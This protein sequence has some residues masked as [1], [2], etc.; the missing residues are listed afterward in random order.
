MDSSQKIGDD[1]QDVEDPETHDE[2]HGEQEVLLN[3][4]DQVD[5]FHGGD[6]QLAAEEPTEGDHE[7]AQED[8]YEEYEGDENAEEAE[9]EGDE[10]ADPQVNE[11]LESQLNNENPEDVAADAEVAVVQASELEGGDLAGVEEDEF[12]EEEE[13]S[14]DPALQLTEVRVNEEDVVE[15]DIEEQEEVDLVEPFDENAEENQV[16]EEEHEEY[17]EVEDEEQVAEQQDQPDII[18]LEESLGTSGQNGIASE[19]CWLLTDSDEEDEDEDEDDLISYEEAVDQTE[20]GQDYR[21][22]YINEDR[23][24]NTNGHQDEGDYP[25]NGSTD[26]TV[27]EDT[28]S[29][30]NSPGSKRPLNQVSDPLVEDQAPRKPSHDIMKLI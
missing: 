2:T 23:N 21:Q 3:E 7:D 12:Y 29:G 16:Y 10:T 5:D 17:D 15:E 30:R 6:G 8:V 22:Q 13:E 20:D 19:S 14:Y 25:L 24:G 27:A 28:T 26:E 11:Q 9:Y 1:S 4:T 18:E